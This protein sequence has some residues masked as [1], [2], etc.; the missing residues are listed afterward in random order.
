MINHRVIKIKAY[1]VNRDMIFTI[2]QVGGIGHTAT[3]TRGG[4]R[5]K[6]PFVF[7]INE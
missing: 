3:V 7:H 6:A 4:L 5:P 2:N 1:G